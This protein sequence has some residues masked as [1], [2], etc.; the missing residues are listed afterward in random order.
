[1]V[2][3]GILS[4]NDV[5]AEV[6]VMLSLVGGLGAVAFANRLVLG[7]SSSF[8]QTT[9]QELIWPFLFGPKE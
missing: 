5:V 9:L 7:G 3:H 4:L 2:E 6:K 1:M 8:T